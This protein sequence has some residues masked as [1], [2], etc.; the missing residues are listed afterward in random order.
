M[1][2][3][4]KVD[5]RTGN[6]GQS[7]YTGILPVQSSAAAR[8][9]ADSVQTRRRSRSRVWK[10]DSSNPHSPSAAVRAASW[11]TALPGRRIPRPRD[12]GRA[13]SI[14]RATILRSAASIGPPVPAS[15]PARRP[16]AARTRACRRPVSARAAPAGRRTRSGRSGCRSVR[17]GRRHVKGL[18]GRV[19]PGA[20]WVSPAGTR[21]SDC[22][23]ARTNIASAT[24]SRVRR[25]VERFTQTTSCR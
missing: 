10:R 19:R 17:T 22:I 4:R 8:D 24:L 18:A 7:E 6:H 14:R 16:S 2:V 23:G 21:G 5:Q 11:C 9:R 12:S 25:Q 1:I 13:P 15:V 20:V 3:D